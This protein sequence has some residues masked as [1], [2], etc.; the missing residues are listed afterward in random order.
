MHAGKTRA[1]GEQRADGNVCRLF[2][3]LIVYLPLRFFFSYPSTRACSVAHAA[4]WVSRRFSLLFRISD[5]FVYMFVSRTSLSNRVRVQNGFAPVVPVRR[6][7]RPNGHEVTVFK[8]GSADSQE[9]PRLSDHVPILINTSTDRQSIIAFKPSNVCSQL[10]IVTNQYLIS[11]T[12]KQ[13][14]YN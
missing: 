10:L 11:I 1:A 12:I 13:S 7:I 9:A 6:R 8:V 3:V 4:V 2:T 14:C 5:G